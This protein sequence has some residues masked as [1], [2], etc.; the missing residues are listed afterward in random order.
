M[1]FSA[2]S[3]CLPFAA[4]VMAALTRARREE[5]VFSFADVLVLR[6]FSSNYFFF[7]LS[8]VVNNQA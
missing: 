2:E 1:F 4:S 7:V 8:K 3:T 5:E 6:A